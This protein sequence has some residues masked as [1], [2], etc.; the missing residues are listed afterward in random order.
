MRRLLKIGAL[1]LLLPVALA[2]AYI[3][4]AY[5]MVLFPQDAR[6]SAGSPRIEAYVLT[7]GVHTDL[8]FPIKS[9]VIDWE[10]YFLRKDFIAVPASANYIAIG[11]GDRDFY[12]NTPEWKDLTIARALGAISGQH[13]TLLHVTYLDKSDLRQYAY[14]LALDEKNYRALADY[15]LA[16]SV[17]IGQQAVPVAGSHYSRQDAFYEARGRY[18]MFNTC[19]SWVGSGLQRAGI[20][21]SRW[22]PF[23]TLVTWH[24]APYFAPPTPE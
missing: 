12:L 8:V 4:A 10:Q 9:A 11:W 14:R 3:A 19:N 17:I 5:L 20:K 2:S 7:N 18:S 6:P 22:T 21:V 23:D 16:S 15:V 13:A 1:A 24:L